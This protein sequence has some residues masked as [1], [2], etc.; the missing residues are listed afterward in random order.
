MSFKLENYSSLVILR[1]IIIYLCV[2]NSIILSGQNTC[3]INASIEPVS[4]VQSTSQFSVDQVATS[5][6]LPWSLVDNKVDTA[7]FITLPALKI[8]NTL[9]FSNLGLNIPLGA[10]IHGIKLTVTGRSSGNGHV[11]DSKISLSKGNR[12]S[13]NLARK[14]YSSKRVWAK[15]QFNERWHY[16]SDENTWGEIWNAEEL[17]AEDFSINLQIRNL[18]ASDITAIIEDISLEVTYTP[19]PTFCAMSCP[20]FFVENDAQ[21]DEYQW[22][23][24]DGIIYTSK[25]DKS[26]IID[27]HITDQA[28]PDIYTLCVDRV[29]Q[30]IIIDQCCRDFRYVDCNPGSIGD[31]VWNDINSNG[32]Q[33][34][35]E[36]GIGGI[37]ISLLNKDN[38]IISTTASNS[39]GSYA[40]VDIQ[41]GEYYIKVDLPNQYSYTTPKVGNIDIDSDITGSRGIGTSNLFTVD[42][43]E[44]VT[45][46]DVGLVESSEIT[47]V[48]WL[49]FNGD[50]NRTLDESFIPNIQV[51]ALSPTGDT[52]SQTTTNDDG[53]Y[54]LSDISVGS[55]ILLFK[56]PDYIPTRQDQGS[57]STDSDI[58][59][60]FSTGLI[61]APTGG[62]Q[63]I[64]AGLFESTSVGDQIWLDIDCNGVFDNVDSII[65]DLEILLLDNLGAIVDSV[66]SD[67]QGRYS[68]NDFYP[69]EYTLVIKDSDKY[70]PTANGQSVTI[71][72]SGILTTNPFTIN[73]GLQLDDRDL[74]LVNLRSNIC[75]IAW[76]DS[77]YD[78]IRAPDEFLL[79]GVTVNLLDESGVIV[80]VL[81]TDQD[82]SYCFTGLIPGIYQVQFVLENFQISSPS[83][84]G[85]SNT[86]SNI[87][88]ENGLTEIINLKSGKPQSNIDA[89]IGNKP[90]FGDYVWFDENTNGIQDPSEYPLEDIKILLYNNQN[91]KIDSTQSDS[92]GFYNFQFITPG[93][94][95]LSVEIDPSLTASV[96]K[97]GDPVLDTDFTNDNGE[98]TTSNFNLTAN[99][100]NY[101]IDLG[102]QMNLGSICGI[103]WL[104]ENSDGIRT[105]DETAGVQ[106]V[107]IEVFDSNGDLASITLTD[108]NGAYCALGLQPGEYTL[109]AT[110]PTEYQFSTD[111]VGNDDTVDSDFDIN[112]QSETISLTVGNMIGNTDGGL[113]LK[114][115]L[116]NYVWFD[117]NH[118]GLQDSSEVGIAD[119][120]VRL[121]DQNDMMI[122]S[123]FTNS[124]GF[125]EFIT[126]K[127]GKYYVTFAIQQ[128]LVFTLP[129]VS[130]TLGS[131]AN[132]NGK[133]A[134]FDVIG[135]N[136]NFDIDAGMTTPLG[137]I[138]GVTWE[139][140]NSDGQRT[141]SEPLLSGI[142]VTLIDKSLILISNTITD[143]EGIYLF[144]AI[145]EGEYF[146]IFDTIQNTIFTSPL[147][148]NMNTDSDATSSITIGSTDLF[149]LSPGEILINIDAGYQSKG[150]KIKGLTWLD[151]DGD[152]TYEPEDKYIN[153]MPVELFNM[154][155]VLVSSTVTSLDGAYE[156]SNIQDGTYFINFGNTD[157]CLIPTTLTMGTDSLT[158]SD[159]MGA[160][161]TN[162]T[163][164]INVS[165]GQDICGVNGGFI[166]YSSIGGRAFEDINQDGIRQSIDPGFNDI[167]VCLKNA[168]G[169]ILAF[170]TTSTRNGI[171]GLYQFDNVLPGAYVVQFTR[172][173][174][175]LPSPKD[176]GGDDTIDSD[177]SLTSGLI[178]WT[179]T[180]VVT[181]KS[182][183][184]NVDLG[185]Y[186]SQEMESMITGEVWREVIVDGIQD[187]SEPIASGMIMGLFREDNTL[188]STK[189][190]DSNG[191]FR[192]T[193][194][195]EGYYYI[196]ANLPA[197]ETATYLNIGTDPTID[198]DFSFLNNSIRTNVFYLDVTTDSM[199]VDLGIAEAISIGNFVWEDLD[200]DGLQGSNEP[201]FEGGKINLFDANTNLIQTTIT[202]TD[203]LYSFDRLPVGDY[204]LQ[205]QLPQGY[206]TTKQTSGSNDTNNDFDKDGFSPLYPFY[207]GGVMDT[208]DAGVVTS[209]TIGNRIFIDFNGNGIQDSNDPG[210]SGYQVSLYD[211]D[212]QLIAVDTTRG[213][214]MVNQ[215]GFYSFDNVRPGSYYLLFQIPQ[216]YRFTLP[217]MGTDDADSDVTS[218]LSFGS[219]DLFQLFP[220]EIKDDVDC[221]IFL[222]SA[223]GDY[224]WEDLNKNGIQEAGENGFA[225]VEVFLQR[226]TGQVISST[227]TDSDGR[228]LFTGLNQGLYSV[229]FSQ[230]PDYQITLKDA[231]LD[232]ETDSD[233]NP[234][235]GVT[236]LISL[237]HGATFLGVDCGY[238]STG[239]AND[240]NPGLS[241]IGQQKTNVSSTQYEIIQPR[242]N[243]AVFETVLKV[244]EDGM[245]FLTLMN[246]QGQVID[247][248]SV[249][250][251]GGLIQLDVS[252]LM[253]GKFYFLLTGESGY[254]RGSL[255]RVY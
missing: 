167:H 85:S 178:A 92:E 218:S 240:F 132:F 42:F 29:S 208:I 176:Q 166:G 50:G 12:E 45:N 169:I 8:S 249:S 235:T 69:G 128:G 210:M 7:A 242:P 108:L 173:L 121:F 155:T 174:F 112:G 171:E 191:E 185:L 116:G 150:A 209:G 156:F 190:S 30:G 220:G 163:T 72:N 180:I 100:I 35:G 118:N 183:I 28:N 222:P 252:Q 246:T 229:R 22:H 65:N 41:N 61:F 232:D 241:H 32:V 40:F 105:A 146:I 37:E 110:L 21:I 153:D 204:Q 98:N 60:N 1:N 124:E 244:K 179:D 6:T 93:S 213:D 130:A 236:S 62:I 151:L 120:S 66:V 23:L 96:N 14:G 103:M 77:Q 26:Q 148:G 126:V 54:S 228:Y 182:V 4:T 226:S 186:Q 238:Y 78:G 206:Y 159:I 97:G 38:Q 109:K 113:K 16:G 75:G 91:E 84:Q 17:N 211:S 115:T 20:V 31:F 187:L 48:A 87:M 10:T 189:I 95:Y 250:A 188:V 207:T 230:I 71:L 160:F 161:F 184:T 43:A 34:I 181:S 106:Q 39:S 196:Q 55:Y 194:L 198:N 117:D 18:F 221:G 76:F 202:N 149:T 177:A 13:D 70:A 11:I 51:F 99:E 223:I 140:S 141:T 129:N 139:D 248:R 164:Y 134:V 152:G 90:I 73:S 111:N 80:S 15:K 89:G 122:A 197:K 53:V 227:T 68:F 74:G 2:S 237:A 199:S 245:Y 79:E 49:D 101:N 57:D 133:T 234:T 33:D 81:V 5:Y 251:L 19:L 24:P 25:D 154:D 56:T 224:V 195:S 102:I 27:I 143:K 225:N 214:M 233:P 254:Y 239:N 201:G 231:A 205:V 255:I 63:N 172:P 46:I 59:Q 145:P 253:G 82:G 165:Q 157:T 135:F 170:D 212:D 83:L 203:G 104:D 94:Y 144:S 36:S 44:N 127:E 147:V 125:Y 200:Y 9:S 131:D 52:I 247:Q 107:L 119:V 64:D 162:S 193:N 142:K 168:A 216:D 217:N 67:N 175:Y 114:S 123:T 86:D 88:S 243:P 3:Q 138:Q 192:F 137:S 58:N 136:D 215:G 47:G 158:D 219:T